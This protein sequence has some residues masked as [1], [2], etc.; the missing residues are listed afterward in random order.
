MTVMMFRVK[1]EVSSIQKDD[2]NELETWWIKRA[3][4]RRG[5]ESLLRKL[6]RRAVK[7]E[8][9]CSKRVVQQEK[10]T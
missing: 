7:G 1:N 8:M 5:G 2:F 10:E 4:S 6:I 3:Y 9:R